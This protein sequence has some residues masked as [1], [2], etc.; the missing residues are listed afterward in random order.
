[1]HTKSIPLRFLLGSLALGLIG[2]SGPGSAHVLSTPPAQVSAVLHS[3]GPYWM[4]LDLNADGHLKVSGKSMNGPLDADAVLD[5]A[6]LEAVWAALAEASLDDLP[7]ELGRVWS[8]AGPGS[9]W[10]DVTITL[11]SGE[12]RKWRNWIFDAERVKDDSDLRILA[13]RYE[14]VWDVLFALAQDARSDGQDPE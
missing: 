5:P 13:V 10:R 2:C 11:S 6:D 14:Q 1:M 3:S 7:A 4:S 12:V 8:G 9:S